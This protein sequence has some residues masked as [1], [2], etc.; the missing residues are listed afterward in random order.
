MKVADPPGV[1]GDDMRKHQLAIVG[2]FAPDRG[3][4]PTGSCPRR[5]PAALKPGVAVDIYRGDLGMESGRPQSVFAIDQDQVDKGAL[6]KQ[7]RVNLY[8]GQSVTLDD[9]TDDHLHRATRS[10]CRCRPPTTRRR[11]WALVS[12]VL[13]LAGL[14]LSLTIK[15]RR[16]WFRLGP[17]GPDARRAVPLSRSAGWP[18]P[19]RPGTARSSSAGRR[20]PGAASAGPTGCGGVHERARRGK[21]SE[22]GQRVAGPTVGPG[23]RVRDGRLS[24]RPG[25]LRHRVRR[26]TAASSRPRPRRPA[27]TCAGRDRGRWDQR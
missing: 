3:R 2:I 7:A 16:V 20:W 17:T 4:S 26:R 11:F 22:H 21:A 13:L 14:M 18:G 1:T 27:S 8:R 15:R 5:Y 10:G 25:L 6:V 19:I 23:V 12:A 9:G 24:G